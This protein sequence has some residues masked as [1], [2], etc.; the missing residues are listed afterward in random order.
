M[1]IPFLLGKG[2]YTKPR[3]FKGN[4]KL[5][6]KL[7]HQDAYVLKFMQNY[8][9]NNIYLTTTKKKKAFFFSE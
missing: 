2:T 8:E 1:N 3:I 4:G 5:A 9:E 7:K 6:Q